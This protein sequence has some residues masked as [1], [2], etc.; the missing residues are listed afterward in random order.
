MTSSHRASWRWLPL[1]LVAAV[2]LFTGMVAQPPKWFAAQDKL[3]HVVGL[4]AFAL[5]LMRA[6]PRMGWGGLT[7]VAAAMAGSIELVQAW[8]P[9]RTASLADFA[10]G[11]LG[12]W[13]GWICVYGWR[14][15][16]R[17]KAPT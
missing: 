13:L 4:F 16:G 3:H 11:M 12:A 5:A 2:L 8:M 15:R 7:L 14:R 10:A 1:L 9:A 17:G 6:F